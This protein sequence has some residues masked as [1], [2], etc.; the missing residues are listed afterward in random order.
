MTLGPPLVSIG[1]PV[2]NGGAT[3]PQALRSLIA[4]QYPNFELVVSDNASTDDTWPTLQTLCAQDPRVRMFRQPANRGA[5]ANFRFVLE[6][7][8]GELFMWAAADDWWAPAFIDSLAS[9]LDAHPAAGVAMCAVDRV[10]PD[11]RYLDTIRFVN[12]DNPN[13]L[14]HMGL[15]ERALSPRKYNLFIYGLFRT[16]LLR[17]AMRVFPEVLGGDRQFIAQLALATRF[18]YCDQVLHQRTHQPKHDEAYRRTA[19]LVGTKLR[20]IVAFALMLAR[21]P[22]IPW[23]RKLLT[24]AAIE[25]YIRFLFRNQ[26]MLSKT[27]FLGGC[28]TLL[29]AAFAVLATIVEVPTW[30]I[31]LAL[32]SIGTAGIV[33][34]AVT[35]SKIVT[36]T[37]VSAKRA[38]DDLKKMRTELRY[39]SDM[40]IT[41]GAQPAK[42]DPS[43]ELAAYARD[44]AHSLRREIEFAQYV[45]RSRIRELYLEEIFPGIGSVPVHVGAVNE[46]TGHPN[47]T[48]MLFVCAI[49]KHVQARKIFEF[50]TYRGRTTYHLTFSSEDARVTTLNLPPERDGTYGRFIGQHFK[51]TDREQFITQVFCDSREFDPAPY[52]AQYDFVFVDGDHGYDAVKN[53]TEKALRLIRPGGIIVWHDYAPK[54]ADLVRFFE[55]FTAKRPLFRIK[56]TCLLLHIDGVD[57]LTFK[58]HPM[59]DSLEADWYR[60]KAFLP[61]ELYHA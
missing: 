39:L 47:K 1:L 26:L 9:E 45:E 23:T 28:F 24:P 48:D 14:S 50:G 52:L 61:E 44:R 35:T 51:G 56:R 22:V 46:L 38:R 58:P 12:A 15:V 5:V 30:L 54:S 37:Y 34:A 19:G 3:L 32:A 29:M 16:E 10:Y 25:C 27:A 21:S 43:N 33:V 59:P 36:R 57:P 41:A 55:E 2:Y 20:Q 8:R 53:D 18:R 49:A 60:G 40:A 4:Q 11:G 7:A 17:K 31:L 42:S 6:Q 13:E